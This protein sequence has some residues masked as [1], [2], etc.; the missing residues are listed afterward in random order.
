MVCREVVDDMVK[1]S[2]HLRVGI[3]HD[4][5][6]LPKEWAG[7]IHMYPLPW[8]VQ[9][10]PQMKGSDGRSCLY[11]LTSGTPTCEVFNGLV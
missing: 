9:P 3:H 6:H 1:T 10:N 8:R 5:E 7:E 11:G 2:G 4:E